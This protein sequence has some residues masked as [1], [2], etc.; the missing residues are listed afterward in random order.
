MQC[1]NPRLGFKRFDNT[2]IKFTRYS[3]STYIVNINGKNQLKQLYNNLFSNAKNIDLTS[4]LK[5]PCA[6][7]E[8][9]ILNRAGET[10]KRAYHE[11]KTNNQIGMFITLTYN[12]EN[13]QNAV[14]SIKMT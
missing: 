7:C 6:K 9:C 4:P 11:Y 10:A 2:K 13:I 5:I 3:W 1:Y 14:I 12:E 8:A